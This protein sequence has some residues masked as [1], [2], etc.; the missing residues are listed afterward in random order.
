MNLALKK[1]KIVQLYSTNLRGA[2]ERMNFEWHDIST[3][4]CL[5]P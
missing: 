3:F 4:S 2:I 5:L 1:K